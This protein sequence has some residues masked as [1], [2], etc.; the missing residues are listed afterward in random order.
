MK[1][2]SYHVTDPPIVS[3]F[4]R[5]ITPSFFLGLLLALAGLLIGSG[6]EGLDLIQPRDAKPP[7]LPGRFPSDD[8]EPDRPGFD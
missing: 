4:K 6:P 3:F 1:R 7:K 8:F 5:W 2:D